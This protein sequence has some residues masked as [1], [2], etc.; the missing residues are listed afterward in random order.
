M[1]FAEKLNKWAVEKDIRDST[2]KLF[3]FQSHQF[4]HTVGMRLIN[5]DIPLF[6]I[7]CLFGHSWLTSTQIY[8]Y[9]KADEL[10]KELERVA[11][12]HKIVNHLG[13]IVTEDARTNNPIIQIARKETRGQTLPIGGCGRPVV[14]GDCEHANK[15]LNCTFWLTST[16]DLPGLKAFYSR[17]IHLRQK[18]VEF[19]NEIVV[20]NQERIIPKLALRIAKLEDT[21]MDGSIS[22]SDLLTQLRADYMEVEYELEEARRLGWLVMARQLA[23]IV[24][25][26]KA[27]ITALEGSL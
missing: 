2:G 25:D 5:H 16:D 22:V 19:G 15:C 12:K 1:V 6:V 9:K 3:R 13:E 26:L 24:E 14:S 27:K 8:A 20:K 10:R 7:S 18:A 23:L 17:A 11:H 21:E 4:R